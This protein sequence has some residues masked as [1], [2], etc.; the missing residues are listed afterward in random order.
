MFTLSEF[1]VCTLFINICIKL[2][3]K[4][5]RKKDKKSSFNATAFSLFLSKHPRALSFSAR[6]ATNAFSTPRE[7]NEK[8]RKREREKG[9]I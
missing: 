5:K 9:R 7:G 3:A 8:K 6:T 4:T 2:S 1:Y